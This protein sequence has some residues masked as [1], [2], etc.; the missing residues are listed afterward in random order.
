LKTY[1][2]KEK[3]K[4]VFFRPANE[5]ILQFNKLTSVLSIKAPYKKDKDNYIKAFT[6]SIIEDETQADREDRDATYTLRPLQDGTFSFAGN[7]II[8]SITLLSVK[9]T[10]RGET[11]S[12][13]EISS[14]N[15]L[16]TL[17][18]DISG[19]RLTSGDLLHAKFRF[20]LNVSKRGRNVTFEI[21]PPN[22]TDLTRKRYADI[23]ADYL[24]E[25][26]VKLV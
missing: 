10:I 24:K 14:G 6:E 25:N 22:V 26:G 17:E 11:D 1:R 23:I 3:T 13:V 5:D 18:E 7:E 4:T 21:T 8:D 20:R 12:T 19:I 16:K 2:E 15:V 9:M